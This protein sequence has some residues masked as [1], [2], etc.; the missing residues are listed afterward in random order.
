MR[1]SK[2]T[3]PGGA[4]HSPCHTFVMQEVQGTGHV[5]DH[6]AGLQLVKVAPPVDVAQDGSCAS[7]G[8]LGHLH[9]PASS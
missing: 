3:R 9:R 8:E 5:L 1:T 4:P 2:A 7:Q 6:H